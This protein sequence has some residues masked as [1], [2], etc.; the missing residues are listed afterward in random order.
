MKNNFN[1]TVNIDLTSKKMKLS[2]I[3]KMKEGDIID[4][5]TPIGNNPNVFIENKLI[6]KCEIIPLEKNLGFRFI[7][8]FDK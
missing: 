5:N 7:E 6:G 8:I 4:F 2:D 1:L 3:I